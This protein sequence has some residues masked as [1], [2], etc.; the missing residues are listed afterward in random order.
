MADSHR[1]NYSDSDFSDVVVAFDRTGCAFQD[2][3]NDYETFENCDCGSGSFEQQSTDWQ[4]LDS[5]DFES[6]SHCFGCLIASCFAPTRIWA[7]HAELQCLF[8]WFD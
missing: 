5:D 7:Y 6:L 8:P 2:H 4:G 1:S 3:A